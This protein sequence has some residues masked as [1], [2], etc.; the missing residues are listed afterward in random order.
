MVRRACILP[1]PETRLLF[2]RV[3]KNTATGIRH[4]ERTHHLVRAE[5]LSARRAARFGFAADGYSQNCVAL[6]LCTERFGPNAEICPETI[7]VPCRCLA[8][9]DR[10][11]SIL[12]GDILD[13]YRDGV[14]RGQRG[15]KRWRR[16]VRRRKKTR[17]AGQNP[18]HTT[19]S[20]QFLPAHD[21]I[22][23]LPGTPAAHSLCHFQNCTFPAWITILPAAVTR[24]R[25][26]TPAAQQIPPPPTGLPQPLP[27]R[28]SL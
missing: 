20:D 23:A 14:D 15:W 3:L 1:G 19:E 7:E 13:S 16:L 2:R 27:A 8:H 11:K 28:Q 18:R 24:S 5:Q 26:P 4:S 25:T 12:S 6:A 22:L 21:P 9:R 17:A 10:I